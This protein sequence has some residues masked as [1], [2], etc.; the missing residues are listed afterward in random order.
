MAVGTVVEPHAKASKFYT[1]REM[2]SVLG[3]GDVHFNFIQSKMRGYINRNPPL[4][5]RQT[6]HRIENFPTFRCHQILAGRREGVR[7]ALPDT[8]ACVEKMKKQ[9]YDT[10]LLEKQMKSQGKELGI[11]KDPSAKRGWNHSLDRDQDDE[12]TEP[13]KKV[14]TEDEKPAQAQEAFLSASQMYEARVPTP[15]AFTKPDASLAAELTRDTKT[16]T[17]QQQ[18]SADL[19]AALAFQSHLQN[20]TSPT[21]ATSSYVTHDFR[22]NL[23]LHA[24]KFISETMDSMECRIE[25]IVNARVTDQVKEK[26]QQLDL[27]ASALET[28]MTEM[29][30]QENVLLKQRDDVS[31]F[32]MKLKTWERFL[33]KQAADQT[34]R[35]DKLVEKE[36]KLVEKEREE[37]GSGGQRVVEVG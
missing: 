8:F 17:T 36:K 11:E 28:Q 22:E 35:E 12:E 26:T 25:D 21:H 1:D 10:I 30:H 37:A 15:P 3:C 33:S 16:L 31:K 34:A 5:F 2:Q 14:K 20:L 32:N 9:M 29:K 7:E 24:Q 4:S 19:P 23:D 13:V 6:W 18:L 27:L